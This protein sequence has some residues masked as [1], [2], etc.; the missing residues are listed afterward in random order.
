MLQLSDDGHHLLM[1]SA[2][3]AAYGELEK[4]PLLRTHARP[5]LRP[6]KRSGKRGKNPQPPLLSAG[7]L[8]LPAQP[9]QAQYPLRM[10]RI[11]TRRSNI[12]LAELGRTAAPAIPI[13]SPADEPQAVPKPPAVNVSTCDFADDLRSCWNPD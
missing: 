10:R 2:R 5:E 9:S 1:A 4:E 13:G 3:T 6:A 8:R 11:A 7:S 12:D